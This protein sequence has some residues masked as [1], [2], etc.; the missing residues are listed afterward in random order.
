M[1]ETNK[2]STDKLKKRR[3]STKAQN[4]LLKTIQELEKNGRLK[5]E[6]K[7]MQHGTTSIYRHSL[8]VAYTSLW[9]A[10]KYKLSL[11]VESLIR[12]ALLHDYFLYDWHVYDSSHRLHGF[13]HPQAALKNA[14]KDY[15]LNWTEKNI[16]SR[17]MFPLVPVP[18]QCREAWL[19]C[20]VD[21]WCALHETVKPM[22]HVKHLK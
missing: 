20:L 3:L 12:G 4:V 17:H 8:N 21:K 15:T 11:D 5:E 19:V 10:E 1:T 18:P 2:M 22:F 9:I 16:I 14:E 6:K 13:S 7:A